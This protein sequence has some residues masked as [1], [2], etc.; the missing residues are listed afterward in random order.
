MCPSCRE[1][2][3]KAKHAVLIRRGANYRLFL[4]GDEPELYILMLESSEYPLEALL[5][6]EKAGLP[7]YRMV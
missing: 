7:V 1:D 4:G 3:G 6:L 2:I 5:A